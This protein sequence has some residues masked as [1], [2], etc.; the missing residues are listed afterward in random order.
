VSPK[1]GKF[2]EQVWG[3][4]TE[5]QHHSTHSLGAFIALLQGAGVEAV[6]DVRSTPFSRRLPHFNQGPLRRALSRKGIAYVPLGLEL[7]GRG[8]PH[9]VRDEQGRISYRSIA[10]SPEFREGVQRVESGSARLRVALLC[11]ER[12]PLQCHRG[13][14]VSRVLAARGTRVVH[15][16]ADGA[17]ETHSDAEL[18]LLR[19]TGARHPDLF[20]NETRVVDVRLNN[21]S[22]LAGFTKSP[23]LP[24]LP[25]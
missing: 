13:I 3:I 16:R 2:S 24:A 19:L 10:D 22:Q 5:R 15:I 11:A 17:T 6:A 20:Q 12:D 4:S 7:G 18:R 8:N 21:V 25:P 23:G 14:L 1:V 9:S